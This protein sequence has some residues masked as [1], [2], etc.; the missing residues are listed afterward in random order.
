M[1][2]V[3]RTNDASLVIPPPRA[4]R[5]PLHANLLNTMQKGTTELTPLF[6][7]MHSGA[8]VPTASLFIGGPGQD[9]GQFYHH[10]SVDEIIIGFVT[11]QATLATGQV[12]CGGR[13]HG[14]NSF[15]K[16]QTK[17][18]SFAL[19][20]VT[21]RQLEQGSQ[22]EALTI[23]C[24][25]C[26]AEIFRL[27]WDGASQPDAHELDHPFQGSAAMRGQFREFNEDPERRQCKA[28]GQQNPTF[29]AHMWGWDRYGSQSEAMAAAKRSLAKAA[30]GA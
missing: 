4:D 24:K 16:D 20:S 17:S 25:N 26:R 19:F 30:G 23:I 5:P 12:Y 15:L 1:A 8:I 6:P 11:E 28:C 27:E 18:G 7:Y 14:V 10:N 13:V 29:P 9:Y 22:P 2:G 3:P 21:Q